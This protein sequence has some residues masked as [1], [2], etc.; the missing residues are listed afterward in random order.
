MKQEF[1]D[2]KNDLVVFRAIKVLVRL[3]ALRDG[4]A[5]S[6]GTLR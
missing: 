3:L 4:S 2:E 1:V 5:N 6:P